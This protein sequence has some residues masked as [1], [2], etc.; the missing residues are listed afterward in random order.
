[1]FSQ[2]KSTFVF[3]H[4]LFKESSIINSTNLPSHYWK[5]KGHLPREYSRIVWYFLARGGSISVESSSHR[6]QCKQLCG[7]LEIPCWVTFTF[8]RKATLNRLKAHLKVLLK[9]NL[10]HGVQM[11]SQISRIPDLIQK[12]WAKRCGL[13]AGV[14]GTSICFV[15]E[16]LWL[17]W[18]SG[19]FGP[20]LVKLA[21]MLLF[22]QFPRSKYWLFMLMKIRN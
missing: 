21:E 14:Y 1:M 15:W 5:K 2:C 9:A 19:R 18:D 6:W 7:G 13:Y 16:I 20:H 3:T 22:H 4:K 11:F 10:W 12:L 8:S 17:V